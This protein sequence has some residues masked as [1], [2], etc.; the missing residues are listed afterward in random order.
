MLRLWKY[1]QGYWTI[2][3][4][5]ARDFCATYTAFGHYLNDLGQRDKKYTADTKK[6]G[7]LSWNVKKFSCPGKIGLIRRA[8]SS[9]NIV[10]VPSR[11]RD[12]CVSTL[13][14]T[15]RH[16]R[17]CC[18]EYVNVLISLFV[19]IF[20]LIVWNLTIALLIKHAKYTCRPNQPPQF[21]WFSICKNLCVARK[22]KNYDY[23]I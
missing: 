6:S 9:T 2:L 1:Y 7:K 17:F 20:N 10:L 4:W 3:C 21:S 8:I 19:L 14:W 23:S 16:Q 18:Y 13:L 22:P 5:C 12:P 11:T 15:R